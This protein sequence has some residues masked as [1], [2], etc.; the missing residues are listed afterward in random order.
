[1]A[2]DVDGGYMTIN[3]FLAAAD[4]IMK[5]Q[6]LIEHTRERKAQGLSITGDKARVAHF[7]N[8]ATL[9]YNNYKQYIKTLKPVSR[10]EA[11]QLFTGLDTALNEVKDMLKR[12]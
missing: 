7:I 4:H 6:S 11:M 10:Q 2:R 3:H 12:L 9:D 1:M 8:K 5:A